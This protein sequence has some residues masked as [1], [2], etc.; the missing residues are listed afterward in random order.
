MFELGGQTYLVGQPASADFTALYSYLRQ[1]LKNPLHAI[2]D[3]LAGLPPHIQQMAVKAAVELKAGGGAQMTEEFV[4]EQLFLPHGCA[5]LAWLL[6]RK[7]HPDVKLA[8][9]QK[10]VTDETVLP[11]LARL[12]QASGM[13]AAN[14]GKATGQ[15]GSSNGS[16]PTR[17]A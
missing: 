9:V 3:E 16:G 14:A 12:Q 7:N 11:T 17:P 13:D 5:F 8:D 6:I 1:R 2:A 15:G 10:H 4:R